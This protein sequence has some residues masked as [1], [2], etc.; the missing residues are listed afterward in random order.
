MGA[1]AAWAT[2]VDREVSLGAGETGA[3]AVTQPASKVAQ[4]SAR[5]V[6]SRLR[7][8]ILVLESPPAGGADTLVCH[9]DAG[10]GKLAEEVFRVKGDPLPRVPKPAL[11]ELPRDLTEPFTL[12]PLAASPASNR[13]RT[14]FEVVG[15]PGS[16]AR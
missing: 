1:K 4:I 7:R 2:C 5:I 10:R 3:G 6:G 9:S 15:P 16:Q 11:W 13:P 8:L 12:A 14:A